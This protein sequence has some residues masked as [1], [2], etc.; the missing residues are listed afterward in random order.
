[1]ALEFCTLHG[2]GYNAAFDPVCPQCSL[3]R[4]TPPKPLLVDVNPGSPGYGY[5]I[6]EGAAAGDR[7]LR[8][9]LGR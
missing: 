5:P 6:P 2:I 9:V 4:I 3:A 8:N 7:S 1:M